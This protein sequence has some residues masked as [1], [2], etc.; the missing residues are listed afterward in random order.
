MG[1]HSQ[2][3]D[4]YT[5][6]GYLGS[7]AGIIRAIAKYGEEKF[8]RKTLFLF[9]FDSQDECFA[10][11]RDIVNEEFIKRKDVYN[12]KIGGFGGWD[13]V[14]FDDATNKH[15]LVQCRKKIADLTKNGVWNIHQKTLEYR[16]KV[17]D[18]NRQNYINKTG[19]YADTVIEKNKMYLQSVEFR[20][21]RSLESKG[22]LNS[23]Y[24]S[25][26]CVNL[27]TGERKRFSAN[28]TISN[29][30]AYIK[31][32]NENQK[33]THWF[34]DGVKNYLLPLDDPRRGQL[35]KGR[36]KNW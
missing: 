4:P 24:G 33:K 27:K 26:W 25:K 8:E 28:D 3:A 17:A 21:K 5:F 32:M 12:M 6:D 11:E 31:E 14:N 20:N 16:Q 9:V 13:H 30:W 34:N 35:V 15:R 23:S 2:E 36:L 18:R 10:K 1:K 22:D 19:P 7:G 29:E